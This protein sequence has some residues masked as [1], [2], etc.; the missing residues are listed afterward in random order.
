MHRIGIIGGGEIGQSHIER[1]RKIPNFIFA[2]IFDFDK[3]EMIRLQEK[4]HVPYFKTIEDLIDQSDIVDITSPDI[5]HYEMASRAL[6]KSRH[7]FIDRP[8]VGSLSEARKLVDLAFEAD[9]K[10]QIGHIERFKSAFT[11]T[12]QNIYQPNYIEAHRTQPLS[13]NFMQQHVVLDLMI[14]DIDLVLSLVNSGIKRIQARG[15]SISTGSLDMVNAHI[16]FDNGCIANLTSSKMAQKPSSTLQVYQ[17]NQSYFIDFTLNSVQ[18]IREDENGQ[19][20]MVPLHLKSESHDPLQTE[21][22]SF[23][24]SITNNTTP[25]VSIM[26]GSNALEVA[27]RILDKL[28]HWQGLDIRRLK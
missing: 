20:E 1:I 11:I 8:L 28:E 26:D 5:P 24:K 3:N 25:H 10:V 13:T 4:H 22:E 12:H 17:N 14:H 9:V 2:G 15:H 23:Q 6:R 18:Q 27:F 7:V 19:R 16:E 21:L